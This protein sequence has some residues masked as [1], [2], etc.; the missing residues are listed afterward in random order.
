MSRNQSQ[1]GGKSVSVKCEQTQNWKAPVHSADTQS[2]QALPQGWE[3]I[4][5]PSE[6][7]PSFSRGRHPGG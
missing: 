2:P 4:C 3:Y 6:E 5:D 1:R 7:R